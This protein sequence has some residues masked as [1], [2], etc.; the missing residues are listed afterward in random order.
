MPTLDHDRY[1]DRRDKIWPAVNV[2]VSYIAGRGINAPR[3]E[4]GGGGGGGGGV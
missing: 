4:W 3:R 2:T 1:R